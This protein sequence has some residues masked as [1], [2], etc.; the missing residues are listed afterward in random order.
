MQN[1]TF[2]I[3]RA[4]LIPLW[5]IIVLLF[6]LFILSI[7][8]AQMWEIIVAGA[9]F[10]VL[11]LIGIEAAGR[12]IV[13]G[14]DRLFIKK[15]FRTKEF[16]W[17]QINHLGVVELGKKVYFLLSPSRG[18]HFFSN[19]IQGHAELV[20]LLVQK[21]DEERVEQEV[22]DY[23]NR[24]VERLS[25]IVMTYVAVLILAAIVTLKLLPG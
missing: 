11:L 13:V 14:E 9:I 25:V 24:P 22:R 21:I 12:K 17:A 18:F 10:V 4:F 5:A 20:A 2:K 1:K 16:S 23:L 8:K 7:F 15:F 6:V 19:M 3:R